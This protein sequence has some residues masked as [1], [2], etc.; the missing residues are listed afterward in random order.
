MNVEKV[1]QL[2]WQEFAD[3]EEK[4]KIVF[5]NNSKTGNPFH[6]LFSQQFDRTSLSLLCHV[7][8]KARLIHKDMNKGR[9][10]LKNLLFGTYALQRGEFGRLYSN[11]Q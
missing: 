9:K 2:S 3:M 1:R 8:E 5:L 10:F 6:V 11:L 4:D 7:A